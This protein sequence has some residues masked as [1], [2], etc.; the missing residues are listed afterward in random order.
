[1]CIG[2]LPTCMSAWCC[3]RPEEGVRTL[4]TGARGGYEWL[5]GLWEL[6]SC[7]WQVLQVLLTTQPSLQ[8]HNIHILSAYNL[9]T[10]VQQQSL[11]VGSLQ[12]VFFLDSATQ[13]IPG[14][15]GRD[16]SCSVSCCLLQRFSVCFSC[17]IPMLRD[18]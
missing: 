5:G 8:L 7:N 13:S 11:Y 9:H 10:C 1:M 3:Q 14:Q 17:W 16:L 12:K 15:R 18:T 2:V 6:N 4:A